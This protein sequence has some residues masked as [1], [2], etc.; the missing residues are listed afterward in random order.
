MRRRDLLISLT[1]TGMLTACGAQRGQTPDTP[2]S[3]WPSD[4][5]T[6]AATWQ[7]LPS[8]PIAPRQRPTLT[9][10][11]TE[12]LV[13]GGTGP[14]IGP[15]VDCPPNASCAAP[16][17]EPVEDSAAYDPLSRTW[18]RFADA[19]WFHHGTTWTGHL[20]TDGYSWFDPS[21]GQSGTAPQT[22]LLVYAPAW[23]SGTEVL[24]VGTDG[25]GQP[26]PHTLWAWNPTTGS[27]RTSR[28]P[29]PDSGESC[30]TIWAGTELLV[31][32]TQLP[33]ESTGN[34]V[35]AYA[36]TQD[37][38]RQVP[39]QDSA[40]YASVP[41]AGW[42]GTRLVGIGWGE[43]ETPRLDRVDPADGESSPLELPEALQDDEW[44]Q[45]LVVGPDRVAVGIGGRY[46]VLHGEDWIAL[47]ELSGVVDGDSITATWAGDRL[48][49]WDD[50]M[51]HTGW[52][53]QPG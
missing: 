6:T 35:Q 28:V 15:T 44:A 39:L 4:L 19:G 8:P 30:S 41:F 31:G 26:V 46:A 48:I 53:I 21:T 50:S 12:L 37:R 14:V 38:W 18:R 27:T 24:C 10:T 5:A 7:E 20:L 42:D 11:G 29:G 3:R 17:T 16:P 47:P 52:V 2:A 22:D 32:L 13:T 43:G 45:N 36:P 1:A 34:S 33:A 23:W 51:K 40:A 9:W 25:S 49:A